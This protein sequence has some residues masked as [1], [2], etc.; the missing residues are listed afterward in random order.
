MKHTRQIVEQEPIGI[1]IADG[2]RGDVTPRFFAYV[3][4]SAPEPMP[5]EVASEPKAA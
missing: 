2:A 3:W 5:L 4:A 1:V